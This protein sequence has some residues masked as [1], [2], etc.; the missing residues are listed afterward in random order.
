MAE[1]HFFSLQNEKINILTQIHFFLGEAQ[2][3]NHPKRSS[4]KGSHQAQFSPRKK[5][6]VIDTSESSG[7]SPVKK[8][9]VLADRLTPSKSSKNNFG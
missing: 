6:T 7:I 4:Q 8:Y 2:D 9:H 5:R 1:I 3:Q